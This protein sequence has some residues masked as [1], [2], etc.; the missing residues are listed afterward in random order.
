MVAQSGT[1]IQSVIDD[2]TDRN[3]EVLIRSDT[4]DEVK[5]RLY[6]SEFPTKIAERPFNVLRVRLPERAVKAVVSWE[7]IDSIQV[8]QRFRFH[9]DSG[10]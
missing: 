8:N 5:N 9:G 2:P 10:N 1:T 3:I 4:P 7:G 6:A